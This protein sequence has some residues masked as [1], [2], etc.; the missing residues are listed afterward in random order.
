MS[1]CKKWRR[2][3]AGRWGGGGG[4]VTFPF[5]ILSRLHPQTQAH[6][7]E[8]KLPIV[9]GEDEMRTWFFFNPPY[10]LTLITLI[11]NPRY[12]LWH[13]S[14]F[15]KLCSFS[16]TLNPIL[17]LMYDD[18]RSIC[19]QPKKWNGCVGWSAPGAPFAGLRFEK[20]I[21]NL[22]TRRRWQPSINWER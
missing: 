13:V 14:D 6:N 21:Q 1:E 22:S 20:G 11:H 8:M 10:L 18:S 17:K 16:S 9:N 15:F 4:G 5:P 2:K 12:K 7:H 19:K 3:Q